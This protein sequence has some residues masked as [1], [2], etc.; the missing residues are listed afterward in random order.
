MQTFHK[1]GGIDV[2]RGGQGKQVQQPHVAFAAFDRTDIGAMKAARL[3][4]RFLRQ[5]GASACGA[6]TGA[7]LGEQ[8]GIAWHPSTLTA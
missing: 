6:D 8:V 7:E 5:S 2:Q 1:V 4:Q 3:G